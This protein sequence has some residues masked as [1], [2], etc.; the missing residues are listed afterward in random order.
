MTW[1]VILLFHEGLT[2]CDDI[3][4]AHSFE[5]VH[6]VES[7]LSLFAI[8]LRDIDNLDDVGLLMLDVLH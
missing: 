2:V 1:L 4:V 6:L 7:L 3:G 5:Y 8:H